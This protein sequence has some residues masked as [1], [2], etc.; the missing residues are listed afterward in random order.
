MESR[1]ARTSQDMRC[2]RAAE[3]PHSRS[4]LDLVIYKMGGN[5]GQCDV[6]VLKMFSAI[7]KLP[8]VKRR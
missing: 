3:P 5:N 4:S 8:I 7:P 6:P 2:E 1:S